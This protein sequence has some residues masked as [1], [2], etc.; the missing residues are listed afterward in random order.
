ML[1]GEL[2]S[3][4]PGMLKNSLVLKGKNLG[5]HNQEFKGKD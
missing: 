3:Y 4:T 5:L 1:R 2:L